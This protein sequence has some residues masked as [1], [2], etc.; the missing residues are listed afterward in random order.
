MAFLDSL[1]NET[2]V[3]VFAQRVASKC[4][5]SFSKIVDAITERFCDKEAMRV[6][7][8]NSLKSLKF[9][10]YSKA[11]DFLNEADDIMEKCLVAWPSDSSEARNFIRILLKALPVDLQIAVQRDLAHTSG[12]IFSSSSIASY[13]SVEWS[14]IRQLIKGHC[15]VFERVSVPDPIDL[16][17]RVSDKAPQLKQDNK[18]S[19]GYKNDKKPGGHDTSVPSPKKWALDKIK[20][21]LFVCMVWGAGL[22]TLD[23]GAVFKTAK[24][25]ERRTSSSGS[26]VYYLAAFETFSVA[27]A[28][29]DQYTTRGLSWDKFWLKKSSQGKGSGGRV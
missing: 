16:V 7:Y 23:I 21:G 5:F 27:A 18:K 29:L 1:Q 22:A 15:K 26:K 14:V 13:D 4:N 20:L 9:Q 25:Y 17:N 10:S 2:D 28:A 6:E 3:H 11:T 19:N 12:Q 24:F 8:E